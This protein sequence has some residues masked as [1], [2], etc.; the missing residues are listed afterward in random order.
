LGA[1]TEEVLGD[2]VGLCDTEIA[3][4]FDRGVVQSPRFCAKRAAA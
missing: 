1:H 4:L 3:Q 2:V